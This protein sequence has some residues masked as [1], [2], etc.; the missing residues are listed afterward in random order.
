MF[1][2]DTLI[3]ITPAKNILSISS[4]VVHGHVGN[5]AIQ[6]PLNLRNW[7]VDCIYTTNLSAHPG[8]GA[9]TS[10]KINPDSIDEVFQGLK[11]LSLDNEYD[12]VLVGYIGTNQIFHTVWNDILLSFKNHKDL[13]IVMDPVMGDNGK[14]YVD[15]KIVGSYLDLL[16]KNEI[17]IDLLT[18]NHFEMEILSGIKINSWDTLLNALD[19]FCKKYY[20]IRNIVITSV[21]I[22]NE[23][24]CVG[25]S[26]GRIFYYKVRQVDA[27]FSGSGDLFLGLLTDEFVENGRDLMKS[28]GITIQIVEKVLKLS[29]ELVQK[30]NISQKQI[31]GK[32]YI[33][34]LKLIESKSVLLST[35]DP[36]DIIYLN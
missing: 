25:A 23:M 34:A 31:N 14:V 6:F 29:Y 28:L 30:E 13:I 12:V 7:N 19:V 3:D 36:I 24:F 21:L 26:V 9:L 1:N 15:Q 10:V 4:H 2:L 8:H 5:D 16:G 20:K 33:P 11:K 32:L 27:I 22:D 18:P 35:P 17:F